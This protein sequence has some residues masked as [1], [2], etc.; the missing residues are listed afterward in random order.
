LPLRMGNFFFSPGSGVWASR[1]TP[2]KKKVVCEFTKKLISQHNCY[3]VLMSTVANQVFQNEDLMLLIS[4]FM[5]FSNKSHPLILR[6]PVLPLVLSFRSLHTIMRRTLSTCCDL[7]IRS[8]LKDFAV[9]LNLVKWST[10][11]GLDINETNAT[12]LLSE[13]IAIGQLNVVEWLCNLHPSLRLS[14]TI[15]SL[16]AQNGYMHVLQ[17]ARAQD[18]PCPWDVTTCANAAQNGRLNVLQWARAE[19]PP[20]PWNGLTCANAAQN[21]YLHVLQWA[22]AQDPPCPWNEWTCAWAAQNG[23]L[24]VLQWARAQDPPVPGMNGHVLG[25]LGMVT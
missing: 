15:C 23:H 12:K 14:T 24:E 22:R 7:F 20:C 9:S 11:M 1:S 19:D 13:A 8:A 16:A 5:L 3:T 17:W 10:H 2:K 21:G 18:P 4:S 25:L 6:S